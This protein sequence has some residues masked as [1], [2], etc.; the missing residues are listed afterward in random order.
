M[1]GLWLPL[2]DRRRAAVARLLSRAGRALRREAPRLGGVSWLGSGPDDG[3]WGGGRHVAPPGA[4]AG[5]PEAIH[6]RAGQGRRR[7]RP[8][9]GR[10]WFRGARPHGPHPC[11]VWGRR[12]RVDYPRRPPWGD[13]WLRD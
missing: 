9:G 8:R 11:P 10:G 1:T 5:Q 13:L 7:A 6:G 3:A 2:R 12:D 4:L